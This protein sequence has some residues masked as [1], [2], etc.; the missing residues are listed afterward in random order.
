MKKINKKQL[1]ISL[2]ENPSS[3]RSINTRR[4]TCPADL[5]HGVKGKTREGRCRNVKLLL[6]QRRSR[7][8][9]RT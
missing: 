2:P 1:L 8:Q 5:L 3:P 9:I 6:G 7:K 4:A